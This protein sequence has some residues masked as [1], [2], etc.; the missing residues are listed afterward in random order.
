VPDKSQQKSQQGVEREPPAAAA[1]SDLLAAAVDKIGGTPRDGQQEMATAVADALETGEHL[2]VQAGTGTGKSLAYLV[3]VLAHHDRA[4]VATATIALQRQLVDRDLPLLVDALEPLLGR[5]PAFTMLKG[6]S[7]YLCL[8]RLHNVDDEPDD[9]AL[10]DPT[11]TSKAGRDVVRI[12]EWADETETGDRDEL[13]PA[14]DERAWR[15]LSVT[16]HECLGAQR[17]P[18]ATDCFAE[19][20]RERARDS[21][22]VVTNHA[23]LAIDSLSEAQ[24][25]PEA[26]VIVVD[27]AHELADRA[28]G[29]VT[30]ELTASIVERAARRS[31]TFTGEDVS[32][33]LLDAAAAL[34][35][36]LDETPEGRIDEVVGR[37]FDVVVAVRDAAHDAVSA[38]G[39]AKSDDADLA[40]RV[41]ARAAVDEVHEI[42]G[43]RRCI[44]HH[45]LSAGCCAAV[46]SMTRALL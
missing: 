27:E 20:A 32:E 19:L 33:R 31:R 38:V 34:E 40:A 12:R 24:L 28:T 29:A 1:L 7:N 18:L 9:E 37:L 22:I 5:R 36:V 4:T 35:G 2:L 16:P 44:A 3:P 46:C 10:F 11:P 42:A 8:H 6:R 41:R 25:L 30:D 39:S 14:P 21:D 17:C 23:M 13:V 26:D 45:C 43:R 15:S